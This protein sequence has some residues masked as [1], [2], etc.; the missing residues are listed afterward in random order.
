MRTKLILVAVGA[1]GYGVYVGWA[2]TADSFGK[3]MQDKEENTDIL[4]DK[5][6]EKEQYN[7]DTGIVPATSIDMDAVAREIWTP[8]QL[9]R[10][11]GV[12][13]R[14]PYE[15]NPNEENE[16]VVSFISDG[17]RS[18]ENEEANEVE[19]E[20]AR[21]NLKGLIDK[22]TTEPD[23]VETF[24][25]SQGRTLPYDNTPPFVISKE[26]YAWDEEE[27]DDYDKITL[28]YY[29][30][31]RIL[32]DD[33]EELVEDIE[34][35]IGW[36]SLANFGGESGS[37]DVVFVRNRRMLTD[38]EVVKDDE[39]PLPLHIKYGMGRDEFEVNKA[40]GTLRL[41]DEDL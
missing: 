36:R 29:P 39:S 1:F 37:A 16:V 38:F 19:I 23:K 3:K 14:H 9:R 11:P 32:L 6:R 28:T 40:A 27:G 4:R 15:K 35:T 30:S 31:H 20:K 25:H 21:E 7:F 33:G 13:Y 17:H 41:R 24:F 5:L 2:F 22:Y 12:D 26:K 18:D 10:I 34:M 8:E